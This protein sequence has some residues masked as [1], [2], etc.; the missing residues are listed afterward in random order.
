GQ[1]AAGLELAAARLRLARAAPARAE[2][3]VVVA[4][5]EPRVVLVD[6][7]L[8]VEPE[9]LGVGAEEALDVRLRRQE[10]ELLVLE[11]ADVLAADL[12]LA[13]DRRQVESLTLARLAEAAADLEHAPIVDRLLEVS[14]QGVEAER[15]R[16][17]EAEV[18]ADP[19]EPLAEAE[20]ALVRVDRA[21]DRAAGTAA[22]QD[23]RQSEDEPNRHARLE[24]GEQLDAV[25]EYEGPDA[26]RD[27]ERGQRTQHRGEAD[28]CATA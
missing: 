1:D 22:E 25:R 7:E 3:R 11:G 18:Q 2:V 23:R 4:G 9:R 16:A 17:H 24:G 5:D 19:G 26:G 13:L 27:R 28:G 10:L 8:P 20:R 14:E 15:E 6:V 12:G 21:A